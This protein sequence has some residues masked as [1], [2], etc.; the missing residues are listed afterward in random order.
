MLNKVSDQAAALTKQF[1]RVNN[2]LTARIA[3]IEKRKE[4]QAQSKSADSGYLASLTDLENRYKAMIVNVDVLNKTLARF[5]VT[6]DQAMKQ[7][8]SARQGFLGFG[9]KT[10][11]GL[12][13]QILLVPSLTLQVVKNL[14][15]MVMKSLN[16]AKLGWWSILLV[17]EAA[18]IGLIVFSQ[19]S[20]RLILGIPDHAL[21]Y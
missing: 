8:L 1:E 4:F 20:K 16:E 13:S 5:R 15:Q 17:F 10:W 21:E 11:L 9:A 6:L 12:C 7:E 19:L 3:I 2:L 18:W 14:A